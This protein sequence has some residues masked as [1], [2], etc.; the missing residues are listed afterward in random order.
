MDDI[1]LGNLDAVLRTI[2]VSG[3]E[4]RISSFIEALTNKIVQARPGLKSTAS[5]IAQKI[6]E[7]RVE[8]LEWEGAVLNAVDTGN[9][10]NFQTNANQFAFWDTTGNGT[11]GIVGTNTA[12]SNQLDIITWFGFNVNTTLQA[13][14]LAEIFNLG[15]MNIQ[16]GEQTRPNR[17][18][19]PLSD[20]IVQRFRKDYSVAAAASTEINALLFRDGNSA[21][22]QGN[23]FPFDGHEP[24]IVIPGDSRPLVYL[25]GLTGT[26]AGSTPAF[27][28]QMHVRGYRVRM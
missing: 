26:V 3:M 16:Y 9:Y 1:S 18:N 22:G 7:G 25:S 4:N 5:G 2:A 13:A 23:G 12:G 19:L 15:R 8:S 6:A 27:T 11:E 20:A 28:I 17:T 14:T 24:M 10:I 21:R